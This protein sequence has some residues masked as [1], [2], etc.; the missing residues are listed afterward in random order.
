MIKKVA[1]LAVLLGAVAFAGTAWGQALF[2]PPSGWGYDCTQWINTST[3]MTT[4]HLCYDPLTY[5]FIDCVTGLP[6]VWPEFQFDLWIE[7][8][9]KVH[10]DW[11][12]AEIHRA[13][14][15]DDIE[16]I[17]PGWI[18]QNSGQYIVVRPLGNDPNGN[19]YSLA[20]M[21]FIEDIFGRTDKGDNLPVTWWYSLTGPGGP[22]VLMTVDGEDRHFLIEDVCHHDFWYKVVIDI[23]YHEEDGFYKM[24]G[25]LCPLPI[26]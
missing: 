15:Y 12:Q 4:N 25:D 24:H 6:V 21:N 20:H 14:F 22:W 18:E 11:T 13:S 2:P 8:E 1:F 19:P 3:P 17:I 5:E 23:E 10:F 16:L 9:I 7:M 26:L